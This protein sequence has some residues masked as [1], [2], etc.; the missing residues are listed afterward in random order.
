MVSLKVLL[1][2]LQWENSLTFSFRKVLYFQILVQDGGYLQLLIYFC[3]L[4]QEKRLF[5]GKGKGMF[6]F[7]HLL[8]PY[9]LPERRILFKKRKKSSFQRHWADFFL[10]AAG[11]YHSSEKQ[12]TFKR[13]LARMMVEHWPQTTPRTPKR[14]NIYLFIYLIC[15]PHF[16]L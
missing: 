10:V 9:N 16:T 14:K 2:E 3:S 13:I 5:E 11:D 12:V 4:L 15:N 1:R 8:A 6:F 7:F